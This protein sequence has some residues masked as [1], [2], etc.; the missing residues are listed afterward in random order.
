MT[1]YWDA[2][3]AKFEAALTKLQEGPSKPRCVKDYDKLQRRLAREIEKHKHVAY[4]YTIEIQ[5]KKDS[6]LAEAVTFTHKA[7]FK[8]KTQAA[9]SCVPAH[10]LGRLKG[11]P[12]LLAAGKH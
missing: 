5:P 8:Q 1:A 2:R 6:T 10:G 3:R 9:T 4:Q 7:A 12:H 11:R